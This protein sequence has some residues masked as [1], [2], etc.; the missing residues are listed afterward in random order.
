MVNTMGSTLS[1]IL[2]NDDI[3]TNNN[4]VTSN[5]LDNK[6]INQATYTALSNALMD[7][8]VTMPSGY[9]IGTNFTNNTSAGNDQEA[10][11]RLD[12]NVQID[13]NTIAPIKT[14]VANNNA[15]SGGKVVEQNITDNID[16]SNKP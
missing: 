15:A 6:I 11:V 13:N 8:G 16:Y 10:N 2:E 14:I 3:R 5:S 12:T 4:I 9:I 1:T 7:S